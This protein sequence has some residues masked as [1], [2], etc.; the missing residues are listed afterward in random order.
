MD[1]LFFKDINNGCV[2]FED[3]D[4]AW[5]VVYIVVYVDDTIVNKA[6]GRDFDSG[7]NL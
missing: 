2:S 4:D 7:F 5:Q 6:L 1:I 3:H